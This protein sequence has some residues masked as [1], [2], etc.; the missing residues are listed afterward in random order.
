MQKI[1]LVFVF[2]FSLTFLVPSSSWA[3]AGKGTRAIAQRLDELT[4]T[5]ETI[6]RK[7]REI[8]LQQDETLEQIKNLKITVRR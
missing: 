1:F 7:A 2:S 8:L 4:V 3:Q 5:V 6:E